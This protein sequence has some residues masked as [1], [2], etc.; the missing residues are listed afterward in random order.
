MLIIDD[1]YSTK[2]KLVQTAFN[3]THEE[4]AE[5]IGTEPRHVRAWELGDYEPFRGYAKVIDAVFQLS[6][7]RSISVTEKSRSRNLP[8]CESCGTSNGYLRDKGVEFVCTDCAHKTAL[9]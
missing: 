7:L 3:L 9:G 4:L 5:I 8:N 1:T 2:I 6:T